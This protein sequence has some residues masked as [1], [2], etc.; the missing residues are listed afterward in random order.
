M[1][2]TIEL[3]VVFLRIQY[4]LNFIVILLVF[5]ALITNFIL[6]H[7]LNSVD[8]YW[9]NYFLKIFICMSQRFLLLNH[10]LW[11]YGT[12]FRCLYISLRTLYILLRKIL[13]EQFLLKLFLKIWIV[14]ILKILKLILLLRH[15]LKLNLLLRHLIR[16]LIRNFLLLRL[17][18]LLELRSKLFISCLSSWLLRFLSLTLWR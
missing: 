6:E 17:I 15:V 11:A 18:R 10:P 5:I 3:I 2:I 8:F 13:V 4:N 14:K 9:Q 16:C 7:L 12:R 1:F